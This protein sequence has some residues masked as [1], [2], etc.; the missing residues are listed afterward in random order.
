[1]HTSRVMAQ[2]LEFE[3][4]GE[5]AIHI[6]DLRASPHWTF[7]FIPVRLNGVQYQSFSEC[8]NLI[9]GDRLRAMM[10]ESCVWFQIEDVARVIFENNR[11]HAMRQDDVMVGPDG[12]INRPLDLITMNNIDK[13]R[14]FRWLSPALA[15]VVFV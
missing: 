5:N 6:D 8:L 14:I 13:I 11:C 9:Y 10:D 15:D 1:M 3:R 2:E 7:M 12:I 4:L